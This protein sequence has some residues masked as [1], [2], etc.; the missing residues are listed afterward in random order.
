M[1]MFENTGAK[2]PNNRQTDPLE[3]YVVDVV[4]SPFNSE[5]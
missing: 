1:D 3:Q 4:K 2:I 5:D